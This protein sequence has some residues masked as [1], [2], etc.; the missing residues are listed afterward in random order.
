[1]NIYKKNSSYL[2]GFISVLCIVFLG[3]FTDRAAFYQLFFLVSVLFVG[4][5]NFIKNNE[6]NAAT[7]LG[8]GLIFRIILLGCT[9]FLSQDFYRFIWDGRLL[10]SGFSP[11]EFTPTQ[12]IFSTHI[13]QAKLL[14]D[15]MGSLSASHFS[16]YPPVNQLFFALAGLFSSNSIL[17]SILIF[18]T[19][20]I[21]ADVGIYF[22]GKRILKLM[23]LNENNIFFYFL[24]PLVIIELTGN[25]HFEGV[26]LFFFVVGIYFLIR[27][28]LILSS[29]FIALSISTKLLPLLL[30][31]ILINYI[32][33]KK[34]IPFYAS[35]ILLNIAFFLPFVSSHLLDNYFNTIALWFVNFE[36]NASFYYLIRAIGFY[37]KGYN[38]IGSVGQLMPLLLIVFV[39]LMAS[40]RKNTTSQ[41]VFTSFLMVLS[42]YFFQATTV[43]PWYVI[44]LILIACFTKYRFPMVWSFSV[45]LSYFAYSNAFFK[46]NLLLVLVEYL[47]VFGF[48][49]YEIWDEKKGIRKSYFNIN[50]TAA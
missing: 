17:G 22:I 10:A 49:F 37:F 2:C 33:W 20:I 14:F 27:K 8:L 4:Y 9:P 47:L 16:N 23:L 40:I 42:V 18:K 46:E 43:H 11:Y 39:V 32:G 48:L 19:I 28:Q 50:P 38:I 29:L 5:F 44:N 41:Q 6:Q 36:F 12:I 3:Y 25:L 7:L 35:I 21:L 13:E 30:L 31:P 45:F 1:M 24:N 34:S 26:M 15:G